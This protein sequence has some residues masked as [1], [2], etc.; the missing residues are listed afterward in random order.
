MPTPPASLIA[1]AVVTAAAA[2]VALLAGLVLPSRLNAP[3]WRDEPKPDRLSRRPVSRAGGLAWAAAAA[4]GLLVWSG[5][6]LAGWTGS[7]RPVAEDLSGAR[8][9]ATALL[10]LAVG[11]W[12]GRSDD[13]G[14]LG[15]R[16]KLCLLGLLPAAALALTIPTGSWL[17]PRL[18]IALPGALLVSVAL[19]VYDNH[20]AALAS[21]LAGGTLPVAFL[22]PE[23]APVALSAAGASLTLLG[24]NWPPARLYFGNTGSM[25]AGMV[26]AWLLLAATAPRGGSGAGAGLPGVWLVFLPYAWPLFDLGFVVAGR[27]RRGVSPW[28]GGTDH[29]AHRLSRRI[30]PRR[31]AWLL[32][33]VSALLAV[34]A[35]L[36]GRGL[37]A[38]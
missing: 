6:T 19:Q 8:A 34:A 7:A 26:V 30:G 27:L 10:L 23:L 15:S 17:T 13:R 28:Q 37:A 25:A 33:G 31:T 5:A 3:G 2:I 18:L 22:V 29:T 4:A 24:F 20:D 11:A 9:I 14:R 12:L 38:R 36:L 16:M 21:V 35:G 1:L 32:L